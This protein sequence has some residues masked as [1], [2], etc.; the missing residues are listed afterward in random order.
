MGKQFAAQSTSAL[1]GGPAIARPGGLRYNV[2]V[3]SDRRRAL[4]FNAST[5]GGYE[6]DTGQW[7]YG[8]SSTIG[9]RPTSSMNLSLA[10]GYNRNHNTWQYVTQ[11]EA[12]GARRYVFGVLDQRTLSLTTRLNYTVSPT[13]SFELYAQPFISAGQYTSFMEVA[14][15]RA[16]RFADRFDEFGERATY[17]PD[18]RAYRVDAD[19]D[20]VR[21]F[22][23]GN[24]DFNF[25]QLRSNA[26]LRWEYRPG[27]T[28]F[29][30][31]GQG[32]SRSVGD[33]SFSVE[34][35]L[36][37]LLDVPATNVLLIKLNYWLNF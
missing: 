3:N 4:T 8:L 24:P 11:L 31:W 25:K 23:F 2:W 37:D 22:S 27:S 5:H 9:V 10:P 28:L 33:G 7:N 30:V 12:A 18:A 32:R 36:E 34:R 1:R 19:G 35:D 17:D 13:L 29:L 16:A 26:V 15:P 21:D 20:G 6:E 14:D